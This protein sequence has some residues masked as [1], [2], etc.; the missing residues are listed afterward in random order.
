MPIRGSPTSLYVGCE[1]AAV[2]AD[3]RAMLQRTSDACF[4]FAVIPLC[5]PCA[6]GVDGPYELRPSTA[7]DLPL[8]SKAWKSSVVGAL[9]SWI[10]P[11]AAATPALRVR[12]Q[13]ALQKELH[14]AS[15]IGISGVILP[16]PSGL[17]CELYAGAVF[18]ILLQSGFN[19]QV[20]LRIPLLR[21]QA[22]GGSVDGWLI[23]NRFRL[24]CNQSTSLQVA[25]E[26]TEDLPD[27]AVELSRWLAEP[28]RAVIVPASIFTS[29]RNGA[30]IL[31]K[32]HRSFL[33]AC[34]RQKVQVIVQGGDGLLVE[35]Q[36]TNASAFKYLNYIVNLFQSKAELTPHEMFDLPYHDFLQAPLQPLLHNLD[37]QIY[38]TFEKD[39]VKYVRYQDAICQCLQHK[40]QAGK[41]TVAV[42]VV[43]AGRGP[44]V[45]AVRA[46]AVRAN[47]DVRIWAVE[48]N[49][50]A[51]VTLTHKKRLEQW[52]NVE[53]VSSDMRFWVAPQK[54]DIIVSELLGSFGD[55]ELSPECI[56]GA[57]RFLAPDG[58]CIPQ[59]YTS[60][61]TP[62]TTP[63]LWNYLNNY[64]DVAHF[65][66]AYVV[67]FHQAFEPTEDIEPCFTFSHPNWELATNDRY[68]EIEFTMEVDSLVHGFAGYFDCVLYGNIDMSIN[69]D[70]YS[71]GMFSWFPIYFP[72]RTPVCLKEGQQLRSH[73][74]RC[75][76]DRQVWY[77]WT[78]SGPAAQPVHNPGGRS[79]YI[80][81]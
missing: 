26:L 70:T 65:E 14:W 1:Y 6:T 54:A 23:W 50:N 8:D 10:D 2:P 63:K 51:V 81:K 31:P 75:S 68:L 25:L 62:V 32:R 74:W 71:D 11:D 29:N 35:E 59:S 64:G 24:L 49:P 53:I 55:N 34:F 79:Y 13:E 42:I 36:A 17:S 57:Q 78:V 16:P 7:S 61:L 46:A 73:W 18:R 9:S 44:L 58:V 27:A 43:G 37:S 21:E 56:D 48:K 41:T 45:A 52:S 66:T 15:H 39:P 76:N 20:M 22:S 77:E 4:D 30:P 38:E 3:L 33:M 72:L 19:A 47:A 60:Y 80:S 5:V 12:C 28:I 40:L 69:P 67:K